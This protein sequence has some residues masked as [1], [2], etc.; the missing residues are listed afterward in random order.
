M[1]QRQ[2]PTF[3]ANVGLEITDDTESQ[4]APSCST[5]WAPRTA[6][7]PAAT[8]DHVPP[9]TRASRCSRNPAGMPW[10]PTRVHLAL[11]RGLSAAPGAPRR[12]D[13][14]DKS[15]HNQHAH[16]C[17]PGKERHVGGHGRQDLRA[18][19]LTCPPSHAQAHL[20]TFLQ[21]QDPHGV[22]GVDQREA[23][24][25]PLAEGLGHGL[26]LVV[27]PGK[28]AVSGPRVAEGVYDGLLALVRGGCRGKRVRTWSGRRVPVGPPIRAA[29]EL[30]STDQG[31]RPQ[32]AA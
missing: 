26:Q 16:S 30:G 10:T 9:P 14:S 25:E 8:S 18:R 6:P 7:V 15:P 3:S 20:P 11:G 4:V 31:H 22:Q 5:R 1:A 12:L 23:E 21:T 17:P 29:D 28:L 32:W 13:V 27:A 19:V 24:A 2:P